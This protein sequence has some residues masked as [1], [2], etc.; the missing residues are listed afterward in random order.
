MSKEQRFTDFQN[1]FRETSHKI[2]YNGVVYQIID[3]E[4]NVIITGATSDE[5][6]AYVIGWKNSH[7]LLVPEVEKWKNS[8]TTMSELNNKNVEM[9]ENLIKEIQSD[10]LIE[11][12]GFIQ[13]DFPEIFG[14]KD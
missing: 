4:E 5:M 3:C 11:G 9:Y 10:P 1:Y 13:E 6:Y 8:A 2:I 12:G 14:E 7:S